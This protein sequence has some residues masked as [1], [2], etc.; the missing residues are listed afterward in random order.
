M[1]YPPGS[2]GHSFSSV[3]SR[4]VS[5]FNRQYVD[6]NMIGIFPKKEILKHIICNVTIYWNALFQ[7]VTAEPLK[8]QAFLDVSSSWHVEVPLLPSSSES[9][10]PQRNPSKCHYWL[11][12]WQSVTSDELESW[13]NT[14]L[15]WLQ[16]ITQTGI[17]DLIFPLLY[18]CKVEYFNTMRPTK[19]LTWF[20]HISLKTIIKKLHLWARGF[21][22]WGNIW[23]INGTTKESAD[24]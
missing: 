1:K 14:I 13:N 5:P 12:Q 15:V 4:S 23:F 17:S 3:R 6:L 18:A 8:I 9:I 7:V 10:C 11:N 20:C 16:M 19:V 22:N 2:S 24:F 21:F